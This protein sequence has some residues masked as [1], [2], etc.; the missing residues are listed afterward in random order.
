MSTLREPYRAE[1]KKTMGLEVWEQ[2]G[3]ERMPDAIVY[4]TGGGTGIVGMYRA[5]TQLKTLG[6]L[7][8][9][10]RLYLGSSRKGA[11][12]SCARYARGRPGSLPGR[13]PTRRLRVYSFRRRS[14]RSAFSRRSERAEAVA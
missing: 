2:M 7:D 1:G 5:F 14:A 8:R 9:M 3:L 10:P 11:L 4:P 6:L 12:R 13:A